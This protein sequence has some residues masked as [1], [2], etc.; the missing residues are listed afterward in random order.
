MTATPLVDVRDVTIGYR[1]SDAAPATVLQEVTLELRR[2]ETLG[3]V[4][5][6]GCGKSTLALALLGHLRAGAHRTDGEVSID[7]T[8]VFAADDATLRALRRGT[9]AYVPQDPAQALTPTMRVGHQIAEALPSS[10]RRQTADDVLRLLDLVELPPE[11]QLV[12]RY[13]HELSGGQQQRVALAIA[14]AG[15]PQLLVLDEPTTGLDV[16]T[17]AR[18]LALLRR[19]RREHGLAMICVSHDLG[20]VAQLCDG[21]L[22]LYSGAIVESAP[23]DELLRSPRHPYSRALLTAVPRTAEA[24]LPRGLAGRPPAPGEDVDGCRFRA[25]CAVAA[26]VC[27]RVAP[28]LDRDPRDLMRLVRCHLPQHAGPMEIG[29]TSRNG[30]RDDAPLLDVRDISMSY[31][32]RRRWRTSRSRPP[33]TIEDVNLTL[34]RGEILALVGESGSGKSTLA[35]GIVGLHPIDRGTIALGGEPLARHV[36][37]RPTQVHRRVQMVF[38]NPDASLNPRHRVETLIERALEPSR[39]RTPDARRDRIDELLA[40]VGLGAQHARRYPAQLSGGEKQRV[41][42]A[43][44]LATEPALLVCDEIVSALDVSVQATILSLLDRLCSDHQ[45]A[46]LFITHDLAVVRALA[47]RVAV[48]ERGCLVELA[49]TAELFENPGA[50]YTRALLDAAIEPPPLASQP[51]QNG[52]RLLTASAPNQRNRT[53]A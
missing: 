2:G 44:A 39:V 35:R 23:T 50:L 22:V 48:M 11:R 46:I 30:R 27:A 42:L 36:E 51:S 38:Q 17:Q 47:D 4:G 32:V 24:T 33:A 12:R 16:T 19:L 41:A 5:E 28:A 7:G 37:D 6:S 29:V 52:E 20:V 14:L 49:S 15:R 45:L 18:V 26:D 21:V 13:P 1:S 10:R 53:D 25:R 3:L 31:A 8:D 43:R 34:G 9:V 40:E